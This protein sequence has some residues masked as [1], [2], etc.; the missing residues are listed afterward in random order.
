MKKIIY[1][2]LILPLLAIF[3]GCSDMEEIVFEHEKQMFPIKENAILLEIIMPTGSLADDE[4]YIIGDFNGGEEAIGNPEW[5]LEKASENS[6][7]WGIYLMP[8]SFQ[9]GKSLADGFT[10]HAK[11]QG[12]ERSVKN[13]SV[14]HTLD[15]EIGSFTNVWVNRW[16][17]YFGEPVK[18]SYSVYVNDQ[19]GWEELA[20]YV[21]GDLEIAGWPG[22]LPTG[23]EVI[24]G[25]TY[26]IFDMGRES[27]NATLNLIFNNNNKGKQFDAMQ[28]FTLDRDVYIII[29]ENSYEEVDP[30]VVPYAGYTVY[31]DNQTG[32]DALALYTWGDV[33]VAGWPGLQ[34]TGT[35]EIKGITYTYFEMGEALNDKSLNLIFNNNGNNSQLADIPVVLNRDFYFQI[36]TSGGVEVDPEGESAGHK[37]YVENTSGW[38]ALALYYWGEGVADPGWPGLAPS[39]TEEVNGKNYISFELPSDINGKA[40]NLI[41]NNNG[42]GIQFDGPKITVDK[43]YYFTITAETA[44]EVNPDATPGHKIYVA[45]NSGWDA[46]ALHYW[47]DGVTG[48][49]WPGLAPSGTKEISGVTYSYFELP[50][51]MNGKSI[52]TIFNNNG[53]GVQF[54]GPV[55][56]IDKDYYFRI[57]ST[58]YEIISL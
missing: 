10:F 56:L 38:D 48:T 43:D 4:Y 19:T 52:N 14:V 13:D 58:G 1:L 8:S 35:K 11:K 3:N 34:P 47:G 9:D 18:D 39:G 28:D 25:V 21:W 36:T 32:W 37:I 12:R 51:T 7:K 5:R 26:T 53:A 54:D 22:L 55:I 46:L 42:A 31:V 23:S 16:E 41:F 57:T 15:V 2:L 6:L 45:N 33:E 17:S 29:T 44:T 49:N 30:N 50:V 20:L 27:K 40:I 24:N